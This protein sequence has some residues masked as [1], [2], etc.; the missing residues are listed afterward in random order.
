MIT[1]A[2]LKRLR[3]AILALAASLS[4]VIAGWAH[5]E[6][7]LADAHAARQQADRSYRDAHRNYVAARQDEGL[8]R[9]TIARF[10][11]LEARGVVGE[12][13]RLDWVE[14]VNAARQSAR[15]QRLDFELRPRRRIGAQGG[16]GFMLT[17][18]TMQVRSQPAHA[19]RLLDFLDALSPERTALTRVRSCEI[20]YPPP[21]DVRELLEFDCEIDWITVTRRDATEVA[22]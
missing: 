2:D 18:S 20:G 15:L 7:E 22:R 14:H 9:D 6:R 11:A 8:M 10:K 5:L 4:V 12:E 19:G 3:L 1:M 17:A 13:A 21:A 16:G